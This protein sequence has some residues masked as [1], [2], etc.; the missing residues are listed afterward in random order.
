MVLIVVKNIA[1]LKDIPYKDPYVLS[2]S[3]TVLYIPS[4]ILI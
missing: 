1:A 3:F 2:K 4:M